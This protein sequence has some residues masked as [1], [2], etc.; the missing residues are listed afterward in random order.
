MMHFVLLAAVLC[1]AVAP[2]G[3]S[4]SAR[5]V[6]HEPGELYLLSF[7]VKPSGKGLVNG[8]LPGFNMDF[9]VDADDR[10][11]R[12]CSVVYQAEAAR[13]ALRLG[14]W[15]MPGGAA[16]R[17]ASSRRVRAVFR[18][19][20]GG[21][22]LGA[23]EAID[24][25]A[26]R[27]MR[28]EYRL[29]G[30]H[31]RPFLRRVGGSF[32]SGVWR[33]YPG[34]GCDYVFDVKDRRFVDF[35]VSIDVHLTTGTVSV[36]VSSNGD[37]WREVATAAGR[38]SFTGRA[39]ADI[40]P[41]ERMFVRIRGCAVCAGT[42]G[43]PSVKASIDGE[44]FRAAGF[45]RYVDA[46]TGE[47][48]GN[49]PAPDYYD[50]SWG[51]AI[52]VS[53]PGF[54]LWRADAEMRVSPWRRLPSEIARGLAVS[55]AA[56]E[57][58][59]VQ[60]VVK[61][62]AR[63]VR[64]VKVHASGNFVSKDGAVIPAA[65]VDV[66]QVTFVDIASPSDETAAP[67]LWPEPLEPVPDDGVCVPPGENRAFWI[68]VRVPKGVPA[69]R[70]VGSLVVSSAGGPD[71]LVP[72]G[73]EVF[74]F[75][76]PDA[77]TLKTSFGYE[78]G[79]VFDYHRA[80]SPQERR[81]VNEAYLNV[82]SHAH[83]SPYHPEWGLAPQWKYR[84]VEPPGT[85]GHA[86]VVFDWSAWD[87]AMKKILSRWHFSTF[88]FTIPGFTSASFPRNG[89][90]HVFHGRREG[91][92]EYEA[93]A[94]AYLGGIEAHLRENGWIDK[95]YLYWYDEPTEDK[96]KWLD[97]GLSSV[98]RYAPGLRRMI[99]K[100]PCEGLMGGV[101]L[102]C[103]TPDKMKNGVSQ[104]CRTRGDD[105]WWYICMQPK[106]PY[107][108]EFIDHPGTDLRVWLWQTW[109][110]GVSG[111]LIWNTVYWTSDTIYPDVRQ[112]PYED[113]ASW[114][115]MGPPGPKAFRYNWGNGEGRFLYPPRACFDGGTSAV[116]APPNGSM[117]L[118]ILR[119][120][121]ED[122]EYFAILS[123]LDPKNP[124]LAV[125]AEVAESLTR[126]TTSPEPIKAHRHRLAKEIA[127]LK[128]D[129]R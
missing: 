4:W 121:I 109:K 60:L 91:T 84:V 42:V 110:E 39:P 66:R 23:G 49:I 95:A 10:I 53:A 98:R 97:R 16:W 62:D 88:V 13:L 22:T 115:R 5:D 77:M 40:L 112:N 45:T 61:A 41:A 119:D 92:P 68:R 33:T 51:R 37:E 102:W 59:A 108:T 3:K 2:D 28:R 19:L 14:T 111:I 6:P 129:R 118:E 83:I 123:R 122:Y 67:G 24:G 55:A 104:T 34:T 124:L 64:G 101:N 107:A 75:E 26:Y 30:A 100:E 43:F 94:K 21:A 65:S 86:S 87:A 20:P 12:E 81:V 9:P 54:S 35:T 11:E 79:G 63:G 1:G 17:D 126:F 36:A 32:N 85:N 128:G 48:V 58:E 72:L 106:A 117:R 70:Y 76:L 80:K 96:F 73:V 71:V 15:D 74:G 56:N 52:P 38:G 99:T 27:F 116:L 120:G 50:E 82:L 8:G 90:A 46:E 57:A 103:P 89:S 78:Q 113:A 105:F 127:R 25:C 93:L 114:A 69:G 44:P 31:V 47:P 7:K 18:E 125:P 29:Q